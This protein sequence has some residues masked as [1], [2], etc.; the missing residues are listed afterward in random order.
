MKALFSLALLFITGLLFAQN[1][2]EQSVAGTNS[3]FGDHFAKFSW[4]Y[5]VAFVV[6]VGLFA[7]GFFFGWDK[8]LFKHKATDD[9]PQLFI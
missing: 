6:L 3:S 8:K 4:V 1:T 7:A 9:K 2:V 5:I